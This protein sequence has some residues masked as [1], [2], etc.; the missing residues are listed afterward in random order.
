MNRKSKRASLLD[1]DNLNSEQGTNVY[2]TEAFRG[3]GVLPYRCNDEVSLSN[4]HMF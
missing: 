4:V 1:P 2:R 3:E